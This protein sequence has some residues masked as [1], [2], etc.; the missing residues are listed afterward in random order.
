MDV[1]KIAEVIKKARSIK[2]KATSSRSAY[3]Y[4]IADIIKNI[5]QIDGHFLKYL[6]DQF[7][8]KEQI[9]SK[10]KALSEDKARIR[11]EVLCLRSFTKYT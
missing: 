8:S 3:V 6:P 2:L 11:R 10:Y 7:L 4:S 9:E 5:N 1:I